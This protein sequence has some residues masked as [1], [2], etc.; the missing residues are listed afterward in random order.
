MIKGDKMN[1]SIEVPNIAEVQMVR[2]RRGQSPAL[3]VW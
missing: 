2:L 1:K 3:R